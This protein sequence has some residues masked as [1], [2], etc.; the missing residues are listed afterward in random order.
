VQNFPEDYGSIVDPPTEIIDCGG[1]PSKNSNDL[2]EEEEE[3]P[4]PNSFSYCSTG[5]TES[6]KIKGS[7]KNN[8]TAIFAHIEDLN[9]DSIVFFGII[10][11]W[12]GFGTVFE[13][14]NGFE[15]IVSPYLA[16]GTVR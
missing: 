9:E 5:K 7:S 4:L 3:K 11:T 10:L 13:I 12:I 15:R 1:I 2:E 6:F 16:S 8:F 14:D